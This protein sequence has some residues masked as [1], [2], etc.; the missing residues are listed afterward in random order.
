MTG[1]TGTGACHKAGLS[2]G[3]CYSPADWHHP[4]F[5]TKNHTRYIDYMRGQVHE[6]LTKYGAIDEI[7]FDY[8]GGVNTPETWNTPALFKM[9][10][11]LQPQSV[12][13]TRCG[14]GPVDGPWGDILTPLQSIGFNMDRAWEQS[15]TISTHNIWGWGGDAGVG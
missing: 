10:R 9:I 3:V 2:F 15:M 7:W 11:E 4:D 13:T 8:D 6:L 1:G 12:A 14:G 5:F